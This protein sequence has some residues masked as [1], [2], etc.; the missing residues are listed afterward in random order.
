MR[1]TES[2]KRRHQIHAIAVRNTLSERFNFCGMANNAEA[3]TKPLHDSTTNKDTAF[4]CIMNL[5]SDLPCDGSNEIVTRFD[6]L[7]TCIHYQKTTCP[8]GILDHSRFDTHLT[9]QGR[10][11]I[12]SNARQGNFRSEQSRF[13]FAV[14]FRT[15]AN[16]WQHTTW[17]FQY[18]QEF[19]I[20]LQ[21]M[22]I[23]QHRA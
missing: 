17:Y 23:E 21:G 14:N 4:Q 11:L 19:L 22:N 2:G 3:I 8:I 9:K 18:I 5:I 12:T 1:R 16:F 6:G 10:M 13:S 7:C 15:R 20:P